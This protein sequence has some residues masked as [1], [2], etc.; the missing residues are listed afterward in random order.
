[1]VLQAFLDLSGGSPRN[2]WR[3]H[4]EQVDRHRL[5]VNRCEKSGDWPLRGGQTTKIHALTDVIGRP[6]EFTLS[7]GNEADCRVA[8]SNGRPRL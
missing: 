3:S 1:M 6:F 8:P 5:P 7:R 4:E 2:I